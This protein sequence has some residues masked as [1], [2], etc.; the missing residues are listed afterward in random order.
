MATPATLQDLEGAMKSFRGEISGIVA[1]QIAASITSFRS[2]ID[3]SVTAA[4]G[5]LRSHSETISQRVSAAVEERFQHAATGFSAEQTRLNDLMHAE[6]EKLKG[7][8]EVAVGKLSAVRDGKLEQVA[9]VL[10]EQQA[11][12]D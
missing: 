7:D 1:L 8:V 10:V 5:E 6:L 11:R 9:S 4:L 3:N 12:M 2:E